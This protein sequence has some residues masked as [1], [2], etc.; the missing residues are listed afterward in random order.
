MII[1][2]AVTFCARK[3]P[4]REGGAQRKR[5]KAEWG[6][7]LAKMYRPEH[8]AEAQS[9][10]KKRRVSITTE[11]VIGGMGKAIM[12]RERSGQPARRREGPRGKKKSRERK[13]LR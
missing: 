7:N 5:E 1:R 10:K 2:R 6:E 9:L 12:I 3:A 11:P 8:V 13:D 4:D